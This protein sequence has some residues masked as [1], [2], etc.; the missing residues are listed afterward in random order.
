MTA[1]AQCQMCRWPWSNSTGDLQGCDALDCDDGTGKVREV[2]HHLLWA[3][4][5]RTPD[6][7][8][9][10]ERMLPRDAPTF[11]A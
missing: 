4:A 10:K 2:L 9:F 5:A 6:C 3:E 8:L 7:P 11:R 1:A